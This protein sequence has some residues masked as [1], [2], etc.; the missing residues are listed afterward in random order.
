MALK[1][2]RFVN[3]TLAGILTGDVFGSWVTIHP[4]LSNL[5][6]RAHMQA[7]QAVYRRYGAI[8]PFFMT[9]TIVSAIPL[10]SL[11]QERRSAAFHFTLAGM[12]CFV[13]MLLVTLIQ[14][15]HQQAPTR[16]APAGDVLRRV[17][18]TEGA[19]GPAPHGAQPLDNSWA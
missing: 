19:L 14:R 3:L 17:S 15:A 18:G 5:T 2:A 8:K 12:T 7:E 4:A 9:S 6:T 1:V 10:L 13:A 16:A 11:T